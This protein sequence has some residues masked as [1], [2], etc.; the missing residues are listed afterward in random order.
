MIKLN[1]DE[2]ILKFESEIVSGRDLHYFYITDEKYD[3]EIIYYKLN[4]KEDKY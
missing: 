1:D 4:L 3:D 2:L